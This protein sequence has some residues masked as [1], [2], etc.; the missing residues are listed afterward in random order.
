VKKII[1]FILSVF[2]YI[3]GYGQN[4]PAFKLVNLPNSCFINSVMAYEKVNKELKEYNVWSDIL[5][6]AFIQE[7]NGRKVQSAHAVCVVEWQNGFYVYDVDKGTLPIYVE[8]SNYN[9]KKNHN[10][11]AKIIFPDYYII[12]SAYLKDN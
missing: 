1:G 2:L 7:V 9:L 4:L 8:K 6:I 12:D 10:L 11:M 5:A 3:N